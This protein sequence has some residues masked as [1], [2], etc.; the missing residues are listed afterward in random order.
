[1]EI[2]SNLKRHIG[3]I[4]MMFFILAGASVSYGQLSVES[5]CDLA[6][7]SAEFE[8]S[9]AS[10]HIVFAQQCIDPN[11]LA[12]ELEIKSLSSAQD[13]DALL[14]ELDPNFLSSEL[15][16]NFRSSKL[17]YPGRLIAYEKAKQVESDKKVKALFDSFDTTP[18]E[19]FRFAGKNN[20]ALQEYLNKNPEIKTDIDYY[21]QEI[22]FLL[23]KY[24]SLREAIIPREEDELLQ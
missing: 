13:P 4:V 3:I 8:V 17:D 18:F 14:S 2:N 7:E 6:V 9:N 10:E 16:L 22:V 24:E 19:Y 20:S 15:Y 5:Y 12:L 1:M 21:F 23:E 11:F